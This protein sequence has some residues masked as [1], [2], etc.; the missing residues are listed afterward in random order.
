MLLSTFNVKSI[1]FLYTFETL[2]FDWQL[3]GWS[4][5]HWWAI[6]WWAHTLVFAS[7]VTD[8]LP[9][10]SQHASATRPLISQ[11]ASATLPLISQHA[12]ATRPLTSQ[13][14]SA[15]RPLISQHASANQLMKLAVITVHLENLPL[16]H[17]PL[18]PSFSPWLETTQLSSILWILFIIRYYGTIS[19]S[20]KDTL[21]VVSNHPIQCISNGVCCCPG[22]FLSASFPT[23]DYGIEIN[24]CWKHIQ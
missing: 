7:I 21:N 15:T 24:Q 1:W 2:K 5:T 3:C 10:I 8:S 22:V 12:S 19:E 20:I 14:A 18:N 6:S 11:H 17:R 4:Q 13:H 9:L 16:G 23:S